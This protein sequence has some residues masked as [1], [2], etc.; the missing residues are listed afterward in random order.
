MQYAIKDGQNIFDVI[1]NTVADIEKMYA[2][3]QANPQI[4]NINYDLIDN[5]NV[6]VDYTPP[7]ATRPP[8]LSVKVVNDSETAT[9]TGRDGQSLYDICLMTTNSIETIYADLIQRNEISNINELELI[10]KSFNFSKND[11]LD[12]G[13]YEYFN[14]KATSMSSKIRLRPSVLLQENGYYILMENNSFL[15]Y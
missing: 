3:L 15:L 7:L 12:I 13:L 8:D 1:L 14:K 11:I 5:P 10:D 4:E 2:F 9:I 6:I